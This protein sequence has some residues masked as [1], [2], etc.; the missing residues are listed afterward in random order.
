MST[1][2]GPRCPGF[3]RL[4]S[5]QGRHGPQDFWITTWNLPE[6]EGPTQKACEQAF[7]L[8]C[9]NSMGGPCSV[10]VTGVLPHPTGLHPSPGA[11]G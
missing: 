9:T 6:M 5:G 7:T 1:R 8:L 10:W 3:P 11:G 4:R 2:A